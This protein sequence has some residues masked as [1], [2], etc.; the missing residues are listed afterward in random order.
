MN[1]EPAGFNRDAL[2]S[3]LRT[4]D[5]SVSTLTYLPVGAGSHHYL[6][7]DSDGRRWFVTVDELITKLYGM[8][9]PTFMPWLDVD[10]DAAF[11]ALNRAFGTAVAL[12]QAG[13]DFVHGPIVRPDGEVLTRLGD[14]AVSV[15][16]FIDGIS[17]T[18]GDAGRHRL[19]E[20]VGRLHAATDSVPPGLPQP[21]SLTVPLKPRFLDT[22]D[23]LRSP[24]RTGPYGEP[25]RLLL[26]PRADAIRDLFR[27]CDQLADA[28]RA[29]GTSWVI[30]HGQMHTA[31]VVHTR[32]DTL[33][34]VDWDCVALAPRERDLGT[35][36][37]DL[38]PKTDE[39]W[40]AYTS[41]GQ[42][43]GLDPAAIELYRHIGILWAICADTAIF[44]SP[45]VNDAD[46][47]HEW[48]NLQVALSAVDAWTS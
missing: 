14:Y 28:V 27:R 41:A 26:Q 24:W 17:D 3:T 29:A 13:L 44:Q 36:D 37:N 30:T 42:P 4:W 5:L 31:N 34:L 1:L 25:A 45:H 20:V 33:L 22:L 8:G 2:R 39:D 18:P 21:D 15:F 9:G 7:L 23:N 40:A 12:R 11:D 35:W 48:N 10:L 32:D 43:R 47:R 6:A 38:D 16:P 19:L 46:T